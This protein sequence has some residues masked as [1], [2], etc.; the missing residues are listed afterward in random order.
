MS[1]SPPYTPGGDRKV[2]KH[3]SSVYG[4]Y[5]LTTSLNS[6]TDQVHTVSWGGF[7]NYTTY[8]WDWRGNRTEDNAGYLVGSPTRRDYTYD[9]RGNLLT[10]SGKYWT[11]SAL[12]SY[13][14]TNAYDHKNRRIFK[15]F[16]DLGADGEVGGGD[17]TEAQWFFYYDVHDRL[18]EIKHTPDVA[19]P[20]TYSLF[21][22][23]WLG[24]RPMMFMQY[25][26]GSYFSTYYFYHS[27]AQNRP[28][29]AYTSRFLGGDATTSAW[30][31]N[32]DLF[33]W[34]DIVY[35]SSLFQPL[36][37][38]GQYWDEETIA[39]KS[40]G[41]PHRPGLHYNWNRTYDPYTG[42]YLQPDPRLPIRGRAT[43]TSSRTQCT[44]W[45]H[46]ARTIFLRI[47]RG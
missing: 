31:I 5:T 12:Q 38:P 26:T 24:N 8:Y 14:M 6:G 21:R 16:L 20:S 45:I 28:L 46:V 40:D 36:R 42:S 13:V 33:G 18:V 19:S 2:M 23:F 35:G 15:S 11:G 1:S 30:A 32:P 25:N 41:T 47:G 34:D 29:E 10:V 17:D 7:H 9:G 37:F 39:Y 27:D 22:Y 43:T 3:A 44:T 4:S